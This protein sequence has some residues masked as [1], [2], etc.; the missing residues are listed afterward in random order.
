LWDSLINSESFI[1]LTNGL[2]SVVDMFTS[3]TKAVG[4]GGGALSLLGAG[5]TKIYSKELVRGI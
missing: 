2:S 4:G 5:L 1:N 3:L